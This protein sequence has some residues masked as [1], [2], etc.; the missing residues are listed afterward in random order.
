MLFRLYLCD[1]NGSL[2]TE[3]YNLFCKYNIENII[4]KIIVYL[5]TFINI[6]LN[7]NKLTSNVS[8]RNVTK[9]KKILRTLSTNHL[10]P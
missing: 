5:L 1:Y 9:K 7:I 10:S 3:Y 4:F 2:N 6:N 8:L